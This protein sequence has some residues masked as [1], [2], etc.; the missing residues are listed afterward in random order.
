RG[1]GVDT[2]GTGSTGSRPS[3]ELKAQF[4]Q[5]LEEHKS[6]VNSLES[7]VSQAKLRYSVALRNLE[8]IS[9]EIHARR[10]QRILRKKHREN[11]LGA[12][13]GS[14]NPEI[15]GIPAR[16][17]GENPEIP[18]IPARTGG[19][20]P[21][22]P[23]IPARTGGENPGTPGIPGIP[24]GISASGDSLSVL[25]LQTIASDLQKFDSV[26]HLAGIPGI[27]G[28]PDALSLQGEELGEGR[29]RRRNFRHHRSVS[30]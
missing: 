19:E 25:S 17:G 21:E 3:F 1:T 26:E 6:R 5:R 11:P 13:G 10:F 23:G 28:I 30:L 16:T 2:G 14:Q 20:N 7:S 8:Q 22:I 9:E 24:A 18:G 27:S 12:E 29:E 4:N 15:P